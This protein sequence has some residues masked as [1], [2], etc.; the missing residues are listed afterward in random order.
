PVILILM[1]LDHFKRVNDTFGH[2]AGDEVL[3]ET[4]R[5]L[6]RIARR[7]DVVARFGGEEFLVLITDAPVE[8]AQ[9]IGER[10]RKGI[11]GMRFES[12]P[13]VGSVTASVGVATWNGS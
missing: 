3:K 10:F 12:A 6:E 1:D 5:T 9:Q 7:G 11:A 4:G 13:E 2:P 8:G